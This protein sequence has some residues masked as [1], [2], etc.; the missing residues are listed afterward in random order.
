MAEYERRHELPGRL[1]LPGI[2]ASTYGA[3]AVTVFL[4]PHLPRLLDGGNL[5]SVHSRQALVKQPCEL[6]DRA[7][8][9]KGC[10]HTQ[11][12]TVLYYTPWAIEQHGFEL[13]DSTYSQ[14]FFR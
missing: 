7:T 5:T 14:S 12:H 9:L 6:R 10:T 11:M 2:C 4:T 13:C 1:L 8:V 3:C